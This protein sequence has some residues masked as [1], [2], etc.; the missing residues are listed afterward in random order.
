MTAGVPA[1]CIKA[2]SLSPPRSL[3]GPG[4]LFEN[5]GVGGPGQRR[6]VRGCRE[7]CGA[8]QGKEWRVGHC[9]DPQVR[10]Q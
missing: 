1:P 5:L 4:V 10:Q 2:P 7:R 9:T 6:L 8:G 3:L